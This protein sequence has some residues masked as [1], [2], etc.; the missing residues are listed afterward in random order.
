[1]VGDLV[2]V[3][4]PGTTL[5]GGFTI[6]ARKTYGRTSAGMICSAAELGLATD[7]SGILVLP[8]AT[9]E[10]GADAAG[11]LGL[12]DVVLHLAIT[13]DRGYCMSVRGLAREIACAYDLEFV[14]PAEVPPLP[15]EGEAW[16]LTVHPDTGVRRFAL[17]PVTGIDPAAVSPWWLQR[18]LLLCGIRATS[19]AVD[20]TNYVMLELG[21]PMHAH[22]RNRI[23][24]SLGV[25]FARSGE[26]V[27]TLDDVER[28]LEP[29]DVLIVDDVTTAAIGG[30]MGAASTE[31]RADSTD[32]LWRRRYG[33][34]LRCRAPSGGCTCPA[35]LPDA[36]SAQSTR[37]FRW[38]PWIDA[39][40]CWPISPG[41]SRP[42]ADR[43]A[44]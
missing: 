40:R 3:A 15:V 4:L 12:D 35:R 11:V 14:D 36:T 28:R 7:H 9:A 20:V 6:T 34:R 24:G 26:T 17:R 8:P 22:D 19:P 1:M 2:V 18:R 30:V 27:I 39:P 44:G 21:H 42:G 29:A 41:S 32:V 13:P 16:P 5:P 31:V 10:P 23:T 33:I 43:L 37:L 25:R 38:P